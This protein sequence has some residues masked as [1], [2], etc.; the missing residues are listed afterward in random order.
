M[1][2]SSSFA[3]APEIRSVPPVLY[4]LLIIALIVAGLFCL[5]M[6][7]GFLA[8]LWEKYLVWPYVSSV[9]Y[10]SGPDSSNPYAS[11]GQ[12]DPVPISDYAIAVNREV[13]RRGFRPLG[14]FF[15]G[16]GKIYRL[17]YDFWVAPDGMELVI[18]GGGTLAGITVESTKLFTR[19]T[20][21]RGLLTVDE[22]KSRETDPSGL[23]ETVVLA[24]AD[25]AELLTRHQERIAAAESPAIPYSQ[26]N[27]LADH[28]KFR[29]SRADALVEQGWA[30]YIDD[31]KNWYKYT[32]K[33]AF[34]AAVRGS[35]KE[36]RRAIRDQNRQQIPRPGQ[37]GYVPSAARSAGS[38]PWR[39]RLRLICWVLIVVGLFSS[40]RGPARTQAQILFRAVVP[41]VGFGGLFLL[42][43]SRPNRQK[44][45]ST[46][47]DT[48]LAQMQE[49]ERARRG[50]W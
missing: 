49:E 24:S 4:P 32:V 37:Q 39:D 18:V 48:V 9:S 7:L 34:F 31:E 2:R 47:L 43:M 28:R 50:G 44:A 45:S 8:G 30:K 33:G 42:W 46:D 10:S 5:P 38:S 26:T 6:L 21:G 20:D 27:P 41:L 36:W 22:P 40:F 11:P 3:P 16:K 12:A 29:A 35:L 1:I 17:R 15:D 25:F 23:T 14:H 19:L 13:E